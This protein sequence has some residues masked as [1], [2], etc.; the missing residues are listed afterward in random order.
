MEK[1][2]IQIGGKEIEFSKKNWALRA[3]GEAI[4]RCG[5]TEVLATAVMQ[6]SASEERDF[7][8]LTVNFEERFYAGG[9]IL[10]SR[11]M[12]R[13]GRPSDNATLISR[14][15]DRTIRP[16]F[17]HSFK[18]ETQVIITCLSFDEENDPDIL[19]ILAASMALSISDIPWRGP[20]AAVR[21][22]IKNND[23]IL[24][25]SYKEREDCDL[26]ILF[27]GRRNDD[28]EI[29]I[30]MIEAEANQI[31]ED[32]ILKA[33]ELA[34]P[35]IKEL[36]EFQEKIIQKIGKE[37]MGFEAE[38]N[39][40]LI[41]KIEKLL[42][43]K[44]E[45]LIY[46][47]KQESPEHGIERAKQLSKIGQELVLSLAEEY[48]ND[49]S[50]IKETFEEQVKKI[51]QTKILEKEQRADGRKLD[52]IREI[53]S[54]VTVI[55]RVH[56]SGYFSRGITR[57][58]SV[59][60]LAGPEE[61]LLIDGVEIKGKKRFFHHYNFSPFSTGEAKPLRS[62]GRREI[63]HGALAEKALEAVIPDSDE[64]PY[65]I[66]IVTEILTSNG[67]TSMASVCSSSLALMDAGVPI[68]NPVAGIAIGLVKKDKNNYRILSDIQ[69]PEDFYGEM[70]FKVAGTKDGVTAIQMDLKTDGIDKEIIKQV[71]EKAK[72]ARLE[73]LDV[74]KKTIS[75]PRKEISE[76]APRI[77]KFEINPEKIGEVIGSKGET[78]KRITAE[79]EAEISIED[80]GEI[81]ITAPSEQSIQKAVAM[82]KETIKEAKVGETFEGVVKRVID[83]GAII[84]LTPKQKG[85]LRSAQCPSKLRI[86][87]K[88]K[89]KVTNIDHMGRIDL[90]NLEDNAQTNR[91]KDGQKNFPRP[92]RKRF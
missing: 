20:I 21:V 79:T 43:D 83:F 25:P 61:Q 41:A 74:M 32:L 87:D 54:D 67:S 58:I 15:I 70:D 47:Q 18:N 63:G 76:F 65:T 82:I 4:I 1:V 46:K 40:E 86:G 35:K 64:F 90:G 89:V 24:N 85:L 6:D 88:I 75:E 10:G 52:A 55:P 30:N 48:P 8:P 60:T 28:K 68:K 66:R 16:I 72:T 2:N 27:S 19:G 33:T 69:G 3:N 62:P 22:C 36:I 12:R 38:K 39:E 91:Q 26:D 49:E 77:F 7:F 11:F 59:L 92:F 13:E 34:L 80:S 17:P 14:L 56:G 51:V 53:H 84:G 5:G 23:L 78:I 81:F 45:D 57:S 9:K 29:L 44:I 50:V 42:G 71:L 37:K 73:I 31:S